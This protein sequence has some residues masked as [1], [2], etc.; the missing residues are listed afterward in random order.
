MLQSSTLQAV[1]WRRCRK[2]GTL[3]DYYR[4]MSYW[5]VYVGRILYHALETPAA[6]GNPRYQPPPTTGLLY[7]A[8][9]VIQRKV[10]LFMKQG[11]RRIDLKVYLIGRGFT[12]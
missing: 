2:V 11:P 10:C 12:L 5:Y 9:A 4:S 7:T 6:V 8:V 3:L 1:S